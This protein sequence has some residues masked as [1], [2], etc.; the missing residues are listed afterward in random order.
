MIG[1][2]HALRRSQRIA[3]IQVK[4]KEKKEEKKEEHNVDMGI[5]DVEEDNQSVMSE[6]SFMTDFTIIDNNEIH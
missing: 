3:A 2:K 4:Q 5:D 1:C 6:K